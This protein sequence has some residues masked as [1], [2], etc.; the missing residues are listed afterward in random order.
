MSEDVL[1]SRLEEAEQAAAELERLER[2]R[3][4]LPVLRAEQARL[5]RA[6][7]AAAELAA[8]QD[9]AERALSLYRHRLEPFRAEFAEWVRAGER[10]AVQLAELQGDVSPVAAALARAIANANAAGVFAE[11]AAGMWC[12]LG[13]CDD[14]LESVPDRGDGR[15]FRG[16]DFDEKLGA[17][18]AERAGVVAY[19]PRSGI[20]GAGVSA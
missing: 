18:L 16:P 15:V 20:R 10:L 14:S 4:D 13:W 11:H 1:L 7:R 5:Q 9:V 19:R 3:G 2:L 8:A 17:L 6:E 12:R